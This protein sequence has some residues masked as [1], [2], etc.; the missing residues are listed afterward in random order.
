MERR[1]FLLSSVSAF[2]S[3]LIAGNSEIMAEIGDWPNM[4]VSGPGDLGENTR[5]GDIKVLPEITAAVDVIV[6]ADPDIPGDF[7]G[8]DYGGDVAVAESL[9]TMGQTLVAMYLND[10]A[11]AVAGKDFTDCTED[12]Q[13]E[14][15]KEWVR[16]RDTM[17]AT[18]KDMMTGLLTIAS[19][20]TYENNT[21]E[22]QKVLF[23]SMGWYDPQDPD[24]TFHIP[25]E[26]Y[27]DS[28]IFPITSKKGLK[29]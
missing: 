21:E 6:P 18:K 9:G 20:G 29:K 13:L 7:K 23:E 3:T 11:N 12:E 8:S 28:F 24:G 1:H 2:F 14:A 4:P 15:I 26:G 10:Y 16:G 5:Q 19:I 22:E 27:P 17:P 25:C